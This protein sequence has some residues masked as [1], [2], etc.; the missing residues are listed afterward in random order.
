MSMKCDKIK[1]AIEAIDF[2]GKV[3]DYK[4]FGSGHINDTFLL[5]CEDGEKII[6]YILQRMNSDIFTDIQGV[7]ENIIGVTTFL[8]KKIEEE[9]GNPDRE[10]YNRAFRAGQLPGSGYCRCNHADYKTQLDCTGCF[11]V[12]RYH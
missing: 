9:N 11:P 1:E 3:I 7:M 2:K 12:G 8:R 6:K 10:C 5:I 4:R